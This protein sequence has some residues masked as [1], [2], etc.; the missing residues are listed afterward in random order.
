MNTNL[1]LL[2]L[3]FTK[4]HK[5]W[6]FLIPLWALPPSLALNG[7]G[8]DDVP[9]LLK[10]TAGQENTENIYQSTEKSCFL[11]HWNIPGIF[12]IS[13]NVK[14]HWCILHPESESNIRKL[15][16]FRIPCAFIPRKNPT[17]LHTDKLIRLDGPVQN[18]LNT[19][20]ACKFPMHAFAPK[21]ED[22]N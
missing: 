15:K 7:F 12:A 4:A 17:H 18:Y 16:I 5:T 10:D 3:L 19:K 8:Q 21:F 20:I 22:M 13:I 6:S 11:V 2:S 14:W 9:F 1:I